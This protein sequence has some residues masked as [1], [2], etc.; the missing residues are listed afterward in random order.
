MLSSL[1]LART[2]SALGLISVPVEPLRPPPTTLALDDRYQRNPRRK[3]VKGS[4]FRSSSPGGSGRG[5]G[6]APG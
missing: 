6:R 1:K 3:A 4:T 5:P 2:P